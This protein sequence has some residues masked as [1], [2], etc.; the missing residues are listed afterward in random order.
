MHQLEAGNEN[1][2]ALCIS[3]L[4]VMLTSREP[5]INNRHGRNLLPRKACTAL[6]TENEVE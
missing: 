2:A 3:A 5:P 1:A 6:A 4:L